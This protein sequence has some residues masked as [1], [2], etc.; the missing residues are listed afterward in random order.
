MKELATHAERR[1]DPQFYR[2]LIELEREH[3][4]RVFRGLPI[5]P[6]E[7]I[8]RA[9]ARE[10]MAEIAVREAQ[11]RLQEFTN[12]RDQ[13]I[14]IARDDGA[15]DIGLARMADV[16]PRTPLEH[17]FRPL[18]ER[19]EK[20]RHVATM[21][22]NYGSRISQRCE[23]A[24]ANYEILKQDA[25]EYE[26]EFVSQNPE[27]AIPRPHF[28]PWEISRLE[29][30]AMKETDPA[31]RERYEKL[32]RES[33]ASS[34]DDFGMRA[35]RTAQREYSR[36]IVID[37]R[38]VANILDYVGAENFNDPGRS[39]GEGSDDFAKHPDQK[40]TMSFER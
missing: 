37:E 9:K 5:L 13:V 3:D 26:R 30:Y 15:D 31:R 23:E 20:Y 29:L 35:L 34:R 33:V 7:R 11:A 18:I 38:E 4:A 16:Q 40:Q 39:V 19:S 27:M 32:Y 10:V 2:T 22:E 12:R 21:V 8:S 24:S 14:V 1:R 6:V 28:T 25:R 36:M 17:L